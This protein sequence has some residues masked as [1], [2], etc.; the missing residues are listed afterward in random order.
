MDMKNKTSAIIGGGF[1]GLYIAEFLAK[2]GHKVVLFEKESDLMTR[3]S[4]NNQARVHNGYHYPRSI[5]TALRSR[6]SFPR[7][8]SEFPEAI[9]DTFS[10]YYL[11]GKVFGK[12]N[13]TQF[14]QF[15]KRI[16]APCD[17]A[18]DYIINICNKKLIEQ[19][20][21]T[22]E[23]AFNSTILRNTMVERISHTD[24][25]LKLNTLVSK[26]S[27]YSNNKLK[28]E[29]INNTTSE[30][31]FLEADQVFNCTYSMLN[32][33]NNES[34]IK[35][36]P[37]KHELTEMCLVDM[38]NM[39]KNIGI[40]V[41]CGPFFSFM[42]FPSSN[43]LH[44][45]SHVRYTPHYEWPETGLN[46]Y[47]NPHIHMSNIIPQSKWKYMI[48]DA[49]RYIPIL[50]ECKFEKSL[51]EIKTVLPRSEIDDSRP[52][53]FKVNYE[54]IMG[55]HNILGGKIDNIYDIIDAIKFEKLI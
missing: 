32:F 22:K 40:T 15:C 30:R 27:Q 49:K 23:F 33:I 17:I 42:P 3:A 14:H 8:C 48:E 1:Y 39:L 19:A 7:F 37:L 45:F 10:K 54:G 36:I 11:I 46:N 5:L 44:S 25:D 38:P 47:L 34:G 9:D 35:F 16:G 21:E 26:I 50:E 6:I 12:V 18:P 53:L 52:I 24:V 2:N 28:L 41:M 20:F 55:F 29:Y 4:Y 43:G 31:N 13:A 51:Y